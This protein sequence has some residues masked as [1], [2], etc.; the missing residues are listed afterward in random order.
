MKK[1]AAKRFAEAVARTS[2]EELASMQSRLDAAAKTLGEI[3]GAPQTGS[4]SS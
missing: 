2:L 4:M 1:I 3:K